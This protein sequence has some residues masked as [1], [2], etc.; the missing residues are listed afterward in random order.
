MPPATTEPERFRRSNGEQR[1]GSSFHTAPATP[2]VSQAMQPSRSSESMGVG[3]PAGG[4]V[5]P[6]F[7]HA[8]TVGVGPDV[9]QS[10]FLQQDRSR[11]RSHLTTPP[12][13]GYSFGKAPA[14]ASPGTPYSPSNPPPSSFHTPNL[15]KTSMSSLSSASRTSAASSP[16]IHGLSAPPTPGA[17]GF[18]PASPFIPQNRPPSIR[19]FNSDRS[20]N[21]KVSRTSRATTATSRATRKSNRSRIL[22]STS[23]GIYPSNPSDLSIDEDPSMTALQ[24]AQSS[25]GRHGYRSSISSIGTTA[26]GRATSIGHASGSNPP[27]SPPAVPGLPNHY[28]NQHN[29][30]S[31][32]GLPYSAAF[33][34]YEP[35]NM[36]SSA[37]SISGRSRRKTSQSP[38]RHVHKP[39]RSAITRQADAAISSTSLLSSVSSSRGGS[40]HLGPSIVL[41]TEHLRAAGYRRSTERDPGHGPRTRSHSQGFSDDWHDAELLE[42]EDDHFDETLPGR[43]RVSSNYPYASAKASTSRNTSMPGGLGIPSSDFVSSSTSP[44]GAPSPALSTLSAPPEFLR[45]HSG[46][47]SHSAGGS[48]FM[49][50]ATGHSPSILSSSSS[51]NLIPAG[52]SPAALDQNSANGRRLL[53]ASDAGE[54]DTRFFTPPEEHGAFSLGTSPSRSA[55]S[56]SYRSGM[57]A[58]ANAYSSS[59]SFSS[60]PQAGTSHAAK[61][62][63]AFRSAGEESK[64]SWTS[65]DSDSIR[66]RDA[67]QQQQHQRGEALSSGSSAFLPLP[68]VMERSG[69]TDTKAS[70]ELPHHHGHHTASAA[71]AA[72]SGLRSRLMSGFKSASGRKKSGS[73][74]SHGGLTS[75]EVTE[76]ENNSGGSSAAVTPL[77]STAVTPLPSAAPSPRR[78]TDPLPNVSGFTPIESWTPAVAAV[79]AEGSTAPLVTSSPSLVIPDRKKSLPA[80]EV[81]AKTRAHGR[82]NTN[83][84]GNTNDLMPV[85][86]EIARQTDMPLMG[87]FMDSDLSS[88]GDSSPPMPSQ[89]P[90]PPPPVPD[91]NY[92]AATALGTTAL[93]LLSL[94]DS[95]VYG[96]IATTNMSP[97]TRP[98]PPP[99]QGTSSADEVTLPTTAVTSKQPQAQTVSLTLGGEELQKSLN[100]GNNVSPSG[101]AARLGGPPPNVAPLLNLDTASNTTPT[102]AGQ[103]SPPLTSPTPN[104]PRSPTSRTN[105]MRPAQ[106]PMPPPFLPLPLLPP[107]PGPGAAASSATSSSSAKSE[108]SG[109]VSGSSTPGTEG[110]SPGGPPAVPPR[111]R[112]ARNPLRGSG[113]QVPGQGGVPPLPTHLGVTGGLSSTNSSVNGH[114]ERKVLAPEA[115]SKVD[116][117][118]RT[119]D[120]AK[121]VSLGQG[122][123]SDVGLP[124]STSSGM[125]VSVGSEDP[126]RTRPAFAPTLLSRVS[127]QSTRRSESRDGLMEGKRAVSVATEESQ[128]GEDRQWTSR[129]EAVAAGKGWTKE[130]A[131]DDAK[132]SSRGGAVPSSSSAWMTGDGVLGEHLLEGAFDAQKHRLAGERDAFP[133]TGD[134]SLSSSTGEHLA[135]MIGSNLRASASTASLGTMKKGRLG[136]GTAF[137]QRKDKDRDVNGVNDRKIA[138]T[139]DE[140]PAPWQ[141]GA[142]ESSGGTFGKKKKNRWRFGKEGAND[143]AVCM[144][145]AE[146]FDFLGRPRRKSK[147]D[148]PISRSSIR[149][150]FDEGDPAAPTTEDRLNCASPDQDTIDA[151]PI[152]GTVGPRSGVNGRHNSIS[153]P[154]AIP[155]QTLRGHRPSLPSLRK[156]PSYESYS[157]NHGP[158]SHSP[159]AYMARRPSTSGLSSED[160]QSQRWPSMSAA[161]TT[162]GSVQE[163]G[164][165]SDHGF[166]VPGS[167]SMHTTTQ[168]APPAASAETKR[169]YKRANVIREL[170]ET[171]RRYAADLRVIR[172]VILIPARLAA[173]MPSTPVT[174]LSGGMGGMGPSPGLLGGQPFSSSVLTPPMFGTMNRGNSIGSLQLSAVSRKA[175]ADSSTFQGGLRGS[176]STMSAQIAGAQA[177]MNGNGSAAV[178]GATSSPSATTSVAPTS[179]DASN[180]SSVFTVSSSQSSATSQSTAPSVPPLPTAPATVAA[181]DALRSSVPM[182]PT[183]R[184]PAP[185][186]SLNMTHQPFSSPA[187]GYAQSSNLQTPPLLQGVGCSPGAMSSA[188]LSVPASDAP[189][190]T[191]EIRVIFANLE[192]CC[193]FA[194]EMVSYFDAAAEEQAVAVSGI[195][196]DTSP[197]ASSPALMLDVGAEA[198]GR[199][200]LKMMPR[201]EQIYAHYCSK[202]EGSMSRLAEVLKAN[203]KG[204]TFIRNRIEIAMTQSN[205]WDLGSLLIKPVQRVL[206]YPLL[207][208]QILE[209]T[210]PSQPEFAAVQE[211]LNEMMHL[212]DHLNE[213]KKRRDI[214]DEV[215]GHS[216]ASGKNSRS[217]SISAGPGGTISGKKMKKKG[218]KD[219][220]RLQRQNASGSGGG[221]SISLLVPISE[222]SYRALVIELQKLELILQDLP[223]RCLGWCDNLRESY[224]AE[225]R[226]LDQWRIVYLA[227]QNPVL[228]SGEAGPDFAPQP[229]PATE[230]TLDP[231]TEN[232][233][234][235]YVAILIDALS[236][237]GSCQ[238]MY[239]AVRASIVPQAGQLLQLLTNPHQVMARRDGLQPDYAKYRLKIKL[240]TDTAGSSNQDSPGLTENGPAPMASSQSQS[241]HS[242][243]LMTSALAKV[244]SDSKL[245]EA[246]EAFVALH[247]QLLEDL[248]QLIYGLQL[249][250]NILMRSFASLQERHYE[251]RQLA[252]T[253]YW[254]RW[255]W[256]RSDLQPISVIPA[257][258]GES[259]ASRVANA[260]IAPELNVVKSYWAQQRSNPSVLGILE[261]HRLV[262]SSEAKR[263]EAR[264]G[265]PGSLSGEGSTTTSEAAHGG[266]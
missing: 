90:P 130:N 106:M 252:L 43:T 180:R 156:Q 8:A 123:M 58:A 120:G 244:N 238:R 140:S 67:Q 98:P 136:L 248:P 177:G 243:A 65:T 79:A 115:M 85:L 76:T 68:T 208:R 133:G 259:V 143:G 154:Q 216:N 41:D 254:S 153:G 61:D 148:T 236:P 73:T 258:G 187:P 217:A 105:K 168:S 164:S 9:M 128:V 103:L 132:P 119:T 193:A 205:A 183:L 64:D 104:S 110:V 227:Q 212:A 45:Q 266:E 33:S 50:A 211:A 27:M 189:L 47:S 182:S 191:V 218:D 109:H 142:G 224:E 18:S 178:N 165:V 95:E 82:T 51:F 87:S 97:K 141:G 200:F 188:S 91:K 240:A 49:G 174:P 10:P 250:L 74:T 190:T 220:E 30:L 138:D 264:E 108:G 160:A 102:T 26:S 198:I 161:G 38:S 204:A 169:L 77:P 12:S 163:H 149:R 5:R 159:S 92:L 237:S 158:E 171:E 16:S 88:S 111:L 265:G 60:R 202:H 31:N 36:S 114:V 122:N 17:A 4:V 222:E 1:A 219:K 263:T 261:G 52:S 48:S 201:M 213:V 124:P 96:G 127:E 28:Q 107:V 32:S 151:L 147:T 209:A 206:K 192:H 230:S 117:V 229:V 125:A 93:G 239:H 242:A 37:S 80:S 207:L 256:K 11:S 255:A 55:G 150:I 194:E 146:D 81:D 15:S 35:S 232:R 3:V 241:A 139:D 184:S 144:S 22:A 69:S 166:S 44:Y 23:S 19:S 59:S 72:I 137:R 228:T 71:A 112:P 210:A 235:A 78:Q 199:I 260:R 203:G 131:G 66:E 13:S 231:E 6:A 84:G 53:A 34:P 99:A 257:P 225:V 86:P 100:P 116:S 135:A 89:P 39:A 176:A 155:A 214:V 145:D 251:D 185:P 129:H 126:D 24:R 29:M 42:D 223:A 245:V 75:G 83:E 167:F 253:R 170:I 172:D 246:A 101:R 62:S 196:A 247:T 118:S 226:L 121:P 63:G 70:P 215:L 54:M 7:R 20:G 186:L 195:Q 181:D 113:G 221:P 56:H 40:S 175:S 233:I 57:P 152:V 162:R 25:L 179:T 197:A 134:T 234:N 249:S 46:A 14:A 21:S 2:P 157:S 94:G 262:G 173:G